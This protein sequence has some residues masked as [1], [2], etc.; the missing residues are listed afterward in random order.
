MDINQILKPYGDIKAEVQRS[1]GEAKV[2]GVTR[3]EVEGGR[4]GTFATISVCAEDTDKGFLEVTI[5]KHVKDW[6]KA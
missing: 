3:V 6:A 2:I 4:D 1:L 5:R